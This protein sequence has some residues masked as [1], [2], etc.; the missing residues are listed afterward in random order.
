MFSDGVT[1]ARNQHHELYDCRASRRLIRKLVATHGGPRD[2]GR[3]IVRDI[4]D[5]ASDL[6]YTDDV[7][8]VCFGPSTLC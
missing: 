1:D 5:F 2:V 4:C 3:A 6:G 7:T 8:L